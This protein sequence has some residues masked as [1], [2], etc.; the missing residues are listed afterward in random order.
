MPTLLKQQGATLIELLIAL[1]IMVTALVG[2]AALQAKSVQANQ[3]SLYRSQASFLSS[4]ILER[5][6]AN[7]QSALSGAYDLSGFSHTLPQL[8]NN[9]ADDD[10]AAWLTDLATH[11]PSGSGSI[12]RDNNLFTISIRWNDTR[13]AI[14]SGTSAVPTDAV[15][16][17]TYRT[18]L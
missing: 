18:V 1:I 13:G 12:A 15:T 2:L 17:L 9:Q 6:R 7:R 14:E 16:T 4:D 11:L 10:I 5:M 3:S 8:N